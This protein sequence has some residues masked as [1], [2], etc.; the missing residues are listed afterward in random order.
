MAG[1]SC[2]ILQAK[3]QLQVTVPVA[4]DTTRI[5]SA[6][7]TNI[8]ASPWPVALALGASAKA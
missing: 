5:S 3:Y 4:Q 8:A 6:W 7:G 1:Q 2:G